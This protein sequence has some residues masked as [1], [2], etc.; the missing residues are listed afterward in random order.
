LPAGLLLAA[1]LAGVQR[2]R[3]QQW[4]DDAIVANARFL[5]V[6]QSGRSFAVKRRRLVAHFGSGG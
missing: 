5:L 6:R 1:L 3:I 2:A 4:I